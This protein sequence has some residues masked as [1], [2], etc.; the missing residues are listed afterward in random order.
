MYD[1][2]YLADFILTRQAESPNEEVLQQGGA[3]AVQDESAWELPDNEDQMLAE[4][5]NV[6]SDSQAAMDELQSTVKQTLRY[7]C[8]YRVRAICGKYKLCETCKSALTDT[9]NEKRM[10]H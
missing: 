4:V 1:A 10:L 7:L 5:V 2:E 6:L 9:E 8:G 3:A